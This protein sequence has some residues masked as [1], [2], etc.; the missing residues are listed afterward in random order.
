MI[1]KS[2]L[3]NISWANLTTTESVQS[4]KEIVPHENFNVQ[5]NE[6]DI[7]V[8]KLASP[9]DMDNYMYALMSNSK[10]FTKSNIKRTMSNSVELR[11]SWIES[12][13]N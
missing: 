8:M 13:L 5:T 4:L 2:W 9:L 12:H 6:N 7:C 1:Q 11:Q 10:I 3:V